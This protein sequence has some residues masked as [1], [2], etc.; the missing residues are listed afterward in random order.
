MK[1]EL[2]IYTLL[3]L[4]SCKNTPHHKA[5][6]NPDS[7]VVV[8]NKFID[9]FYS[10]NRDSL[11]SILSQARESRPGILYY[12]RWAQCGHYEI[13][14]RGKYIEQNDSLVIFPVT[15]K[16]DLMGALDIDFHV[17]DTFHLAI[18]YG[19]IRSVKTS[20][21][22]PEVYYEAKKWVQ[23]NRPDLVKK[24]CEGIWEGGPT[25]CEC[26]QGMVKGF[27]EFKANGKTN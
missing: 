5:P 27:A 6:V 19:K 12:Q 20:S 10:F 26:V 22:D 4:G 3:L 1:I 16:D 14:Q 25:P 11:G 17:T 18:R 21:N 24:A 9:A 8:A 15:V 23:Q 2:I 13:V 7:N